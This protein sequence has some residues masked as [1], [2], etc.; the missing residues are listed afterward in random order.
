MSKLFVRGTSFACLLLTL[1]ACS[2]EKKKSKPPER[3]VPNEYIMKA[4]C[5]NQPEV[6]ENSFAFSDTENVQTANF[7]KKYD[8]NRVNAMMKL[9]LKASSD[10]VKASGNNLEYKSPVQLYRIS[11]STEYCKP[12]EGFLA[13]PPADLK[14]Y[15]TEASGG[16]GS[17]KILVGLYAPIGQE[18]VPS[19]LDIPAIMVV[20]F[21]AKWTLVHEFMHHLFRVEIRK[22]VDQGVTQNDAVVYNR[23]VASVDDVIQ[24]EKDHKEAPAHK[25]DEAV[26]K[27]AH[28]YL[29]AADLANEVAIRYPLEEMT[30]EK[31]LIDKH[32]AG[33]FEEVHKLELVSGASYMA[34]SYEKTRKVLNPFR[35]SMYRMS[36]HLSGKKEHEQLIKDLDKM[37]QKLDKTISEATT[38]RTDADNILADFKYNPEE[39]TGVTSGETITVP[40][41]NCSHGQDFEAIEV[42][43]FTP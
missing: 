40:H 7:G 1:A 18:Q 32:K 13:D 25:K 16:V 5:A 10:Y 43:L 6:G 41:T 14:N 36:Y 33:K 24:A 39:Y 17:G 12:S 22:L 2:E 42:P 29:Y 23:F 28:T 27:V 11:T 4:S 35:E 30:I 37:V 20:D 9:S 3:V 26:I 21:A 38:L 19:V 8:L 34:S 31:I 15:F